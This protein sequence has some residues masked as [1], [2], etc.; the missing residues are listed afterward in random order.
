[1]RMRLEGGR[2][3]TPPWQR[4]PRALSLPPHDIRTSR[5]ISYQPPSSVSVRLSSSLACWLSIYRSFALR[6]V[7]WRLVGVGGGIYKKQKH[8]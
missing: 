7:V 1:M 8:L 4:A 3:K 6:F 2:K 5:R